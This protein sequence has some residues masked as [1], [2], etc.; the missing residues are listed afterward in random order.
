[1]KLLATTFTAFSL[2]A[3]A[4]AF[5]QAGGRSASDPS[6]IESLQGSQAIK[7]TRSG[8]QPPAVGSAD[9]FTGSVH[10]DP[11]FSENPPAH[12][13]GA[14]VTFEAAARTAW[15]SHPLGQTLIVMA[16]RGWVQQGAS[17]SLRTES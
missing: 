12:A 13:S 3:S 6:Q 11:L 15:H 7:V 2:L 14:S 16:C 8:S 5:A 1:M 4:S 17:L 9:H 10:V